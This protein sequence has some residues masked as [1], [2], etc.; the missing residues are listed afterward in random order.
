VVRKDPKTGEEITYNVKCAFPSPL[1]VKS[2][3]RPRDLIRKDLKTGE[4]I[5]YDVKC[6]LA[7]SCSITN[8]S[9]DCSP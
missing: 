5:T 1:A 6:A 3:S 7:Y 2:H 4:E 9:D 8:K